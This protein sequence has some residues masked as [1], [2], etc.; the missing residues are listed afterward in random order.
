MVL[1]NRPIVFLFNDLIF[2]YEYFSYCVVIR[3]HVVFVYNIPSKKYFPSIIL[4]HTWVRHVS[5]SLDTPGG[6]FAGPDLG[7]FNPLK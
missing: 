6:S 4:D 2:D 7:T 1:S 3:K 5:N